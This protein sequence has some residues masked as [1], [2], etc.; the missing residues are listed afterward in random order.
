MTEEPQLGLSR[1]FEAGPQDLPPPSR[2]L[3]HLKSK[4]D[5][6]P[7]AGRGAGYERIRKLLRRALGA[8]KTEDYG[9]CCQLTLEAL[10]IDQNHP[11]ANHVMAVGL[12]RLG[13][14]HKAI[15]FYERA[16]A[17]DPS[18]LEIYFNLGLVAW[19]LKMY[20]AAE[21]LFRIYIDRA[22][23]K[24]EGF[25]NLGGVL[26]DQG[27]FESAIDVLRGAI[28]RLP[29]EPQLWNSLGTV[30]METDAIGQARIF[31]EEAI[32]LKPDYGRAFHNLGYLLNHIGPFDE[33]LDAYDKALE[34][35]L[36]PSDKVETEHARAICLFHLGRLE[37]GFKQ[38]EVR[39]E[40]R[41]K[42]AP[43]YGFRI[44]R[45]QGEPLEGKKLLLIAEQG[46][47]DEIMFASAMPDLIAE[48]GPAGKVAIACAPRLTTLFG[49]SFP[50]EIV[51]SY[52]DLKQSERQIRNVPWLGKLGTVDFYSPFGSTLQYRRRDIRDFESK[53][54]LLKPDTEK[55]R[56][57]RERL[58]VLGPGPY[59]GV[60]WKSLVM[61]AKRAKFYSPI[62]HWG[63]IFAVPGA[64][65]INLQYGDC[66]ADIKEAQDRFGVTIHNFEDLDLKIDLDGNAAL[67]SA[68]D[69]MI[70]AP[71]AASAIAGGV[72]LEVWFITLC[73]VWPQLG[74]DRMPWY[75]ET[76]VFVPTTYGDFADG[77]ARAG[78]ALRERI[79][80]SRASAA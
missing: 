49:R 19:R 54:P 9:E 62:E 10:D 20:E 28:Y 76:R 53:P 71:N 17:L 79:E 31:L 1:H 73:E 12:E 40:A 39:T 6:K 46:L 33:A 30:L 7:T 65:F 45:W 23:E 47:G 43:A 80:T 25:N 14:L 32:R 16:L 3:D 55:A 5:A 64:K 75:P 61:T 78:Q 2:A 4:L 70:T 52:Q 72:G 68:L 29:E 11:Q 69:L 57:W 34:L 26:R 56:A 77:L 42:A 13:E 41:Y 24:A 48:V 21:R 35:P 66:A 44:P 60:C 37:E 63:A 27:K 74:T 22:P 18:D 38:W 58:G 15:Q 36:P 50:T 8:Y 67:C 59:V 51:G